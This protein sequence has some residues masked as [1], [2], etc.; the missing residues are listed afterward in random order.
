MST[1]ADYPYEWKKKRRF[2]L[3]DVLLSLGVLVIIIVAANIIPNLGSQ[4]PAAPTPTPSYIVRGTR[5][6]PSVVPVEVEFPAP[7]LNISDLEGTPVS[8]GS[9]RGQVVLLNN[10]MID[11]PFCE[12]E[13]PEFEAFYNNHK[14]KGLTVIG[15][16]GDDPVEDV[17]EYTQNMAITFPV[18]SDPKRR[19]IQA[20]NN[21]NL[22]NSYVIDK[23][24]T[25]RLSWTGPI[26]LAILEQFV[27]P[28]LEE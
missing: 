23:A 17:K 6:I 25:V 2:G 19:S 27:T 22:P 13:M 14:S 4:E 9:Y 7:D 1:N 16:N 8:L 11:C 24:G 3:K 18:W 10:W 21:T 5:K 26:S 20:F 15:V 12:S 28:L